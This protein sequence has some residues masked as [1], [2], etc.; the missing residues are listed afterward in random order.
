[1]IRVVIHWRQHP[2]DM[3]SAARMYTT[4]SPEHGNTLVL[5]DSEGYE[6]NITLSLVVGITVMDHG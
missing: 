3:F 6:R 4:H 1:M 2:S 5:V